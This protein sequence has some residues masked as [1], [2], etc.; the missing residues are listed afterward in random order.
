[1]SVWRYRILPVMDDLDN[2]HTR[3]TGTAAG[4]GYW[5]DA[6]MAVETVRD[7]LDGAVFPVQ[8]VRLPPRTPEHVRL[9][10]RLNFPGLRVE[11]EQ[12]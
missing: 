11:V 5:D 9:A 7:L 2:G 3:V 1:M 12:A 8:S 4:D 6:G 10:I